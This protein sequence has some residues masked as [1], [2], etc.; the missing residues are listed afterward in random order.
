MSELGNYEAQAELYRA[1]V[2]D[3]GLQQ[4]VEDRFY[5]RVAEQD[6]EFP[7]I[8]YTQINDANTKHADNKETKATVNFQ[9][10][11]FTDAETVMHETQIYKEIDRIMKS[12]EYGRYDYQGLYESD[13]KLHHLALRYEKN[14][15]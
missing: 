1:L 4:F 15:Y 14:F 3:E 13:T 12:I 7:R 9:I 6:A 10:S 11:V 5:N 2:N 8:V